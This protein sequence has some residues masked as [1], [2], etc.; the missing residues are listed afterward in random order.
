MTT[1]TVT[2]VAEHNMIRRACAGDRA[3]FEGLMQTYQPALYNLCYRYMGNAA[4]AEEA[5]QEAFLRAYTKL[6]RYDQSRPFKTW[7]FTI[8][9]NYCIDRLRRRRLRWLS[10]DDESVAESFAWR[11]AAPTPEEAAMR[12]EQAEDVQAAL[13]RLP[14]RDRSVVV[15][16]Y[17]NG[18]SYEEIAQVT[19]ATVSS[20]KSRLHRA[21]GALAVHVS[22]A[23]PR[24]APCA[25]MNRSTSAA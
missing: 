2:S 20:V 15:L 18:L 14:S 16:R 8:T 25:A 6:C 1:V 10:L 13:N 4:D 17:W 12:H 9:H 5:S 7:L 24:E 19:G 23:P 22:P 3:A 11:G 21:R